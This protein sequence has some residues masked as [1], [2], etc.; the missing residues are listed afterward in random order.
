M[1]RDLRLAARSFAPLAKALLASLA[2][3]RATSRVFVTAGL[4]VLGVVSRTCAGTS[5][6]EADWIS[7]C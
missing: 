5:Y 6:G 4:L 7:R 2:Q 3:S 1:T